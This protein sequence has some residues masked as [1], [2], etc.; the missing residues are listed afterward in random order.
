M[1]HNVAREIMLLAQENA[2]TIV[3]VTLGVKTM[4]GLQLTHIV[5]AF[6]PTSIKGRLL[7]QSRGV[8]LPAEN[9]DAALAIIESAFK[10]LYKCHRLWA[11]IQQRARAAAT[12]R[13]LLAFAVRPDQTTESRRHALH[14]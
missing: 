4:D 10:I 9:D 11:W 6:A 14:R 8:K 2:R 3:Q 13:Q 1:A 5:S 7:I 12:S